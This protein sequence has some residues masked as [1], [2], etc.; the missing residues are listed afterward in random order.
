MEKIKK[1]LITTKNEYRYLP[2]TECVRYVS[3]LLY[4]NDYFLQTYVPKTKKAKEV[5]LRIAEI[6]DDDKVEHYTVLL[7]YRVCFKQCSGYIDVYIKEK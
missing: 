1:L 3:T 2:F 4:D 5:S 7:N 6:N